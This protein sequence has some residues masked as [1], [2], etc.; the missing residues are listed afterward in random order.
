MFGA[1]S[2]TECTTL[3]PSDL[4]TENVRDLATDTGV[5]SVRE[6]L[7]CVSL[8][9]LVGERGE[10]VREFGFGRVGDGD[11]EPVRLF[12]LDC[13]NLSVQSL[14]RASIESLEAKW[15]EITCQMQQM[16]EK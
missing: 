12:S 14:L 1:L 13:E 6:H 3:P 5:D 4:V 15:L 8:V 10:A 16:E 9:Y 2:G 11:M 7:I